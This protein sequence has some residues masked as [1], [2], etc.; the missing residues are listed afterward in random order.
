MKFFLNADDDLI[1]IFILV[2]DGELFQVGEDPA[3]VVSELGQ[4][5]PLLTLHH[6][7]LTIKYDLE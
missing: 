6:P 1:F 3:D 2:A 5:G 4:G 7:C